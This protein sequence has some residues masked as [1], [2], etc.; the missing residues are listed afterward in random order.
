M[1]VLKT[2]FYILQMVGINLLFI[3]VVIK[4]LYHIAWPHIQA[5][6]NKRNWN[7]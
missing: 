4:L 2:V 3:G 7:E 6:L 5:I 1:D